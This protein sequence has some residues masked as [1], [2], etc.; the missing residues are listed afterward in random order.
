MGQTT[1]YIGL[2]IP[3]TGETNYDQAFA[4][5]MVNLDQHD[6]S[7][8][9]NKGV[10]ITTSG[11]ADFSVTYQKLNSNVADSSTGIG[12]Q[13]SPF[14]NRLQALGILKNLFALANGGATGFVSMNG[15]VVAGRTFTVGTGLAIANADGISG[16]P[17][18]TLTS[19]IASSIIG[20]AN[21]IAVSTPLPNQY[22]IGFA[23]I[24]QNATQPVFMA[25]IGASQ[26]NVTGEGTAYTVLFPTVTVNQGGYYNAGSSTF[27]A[28]VTGNYLLGVNLYI[29]DI[30]SGGSTKNATQIDF[31]INGSLG[32]TV[33]FGDTR[34]FNASGSTHVQL[35]ATEFMQLT[36]GQQVTVVLTVTTT[37][38]T[39]KLIDVDEAYFSG[40]LLW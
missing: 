32:R 24:T 8:G 22:Q 21:Q 40:V 25:Q 1:P 30:T 6:H 3:A 16:N 23:P 7:G 14:Q 4:A 28:P 18:I 36:A 33:F 15:A 10:P 27:T 9:P 37:P 5:G 12:T 31:Y 17:L 39:G 26:D 35:S 38:S 2:F 19:A 11:L 13:G 29:G 20:T 34:A